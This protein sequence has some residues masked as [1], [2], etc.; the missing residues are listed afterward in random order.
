MADL[1][2]TYNTPKFPGALSGRQK[3]YLGLKES[4]VDT[5]KKEVEDFL[6][7]QDS[8]T[9][10]YPARRKIKRNR[11][12]V[13]GSSHLAQVDLLSMVSLSP[14]NDGYKYIICFVDVLSKF[15]Y[16]E[17]LKSKK[18]QDIIS[19]FRKILNRAVKQNRLPYR[20]ATDMGGEFMSAKWNKL[21]REYA[22][23]H[24]TL[25][26]TETKATN[27]EI[28]QKTLKRL[29]YKFLTASGSR[30]Y[31]DKLQELMENYNRS[32]H[33]TIGTAP[34][35]VKK[36]GL[37]EQL[38]WRRQYE[39]P[40]PPKPDGAFKFKV[41]DYVRLSHVAKPFDREYNQKYTREVFQVSS[42]K[43]RALLN[44]YR[45]SDLNKTEI[46]GF[47]YQSELQKISFDESG[48]FK[49]E[50]ILRTKKVKGQKYYLVRWQDYGPSMDSWVSSDDMVD[51]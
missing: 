49:V 45:V 24:Y 30:R 36:G 19:A 4:G 23:E 3:F 1:E 50:K 48:T 40:K 32:Y 42:R 41:K 15:A 38:V 21:M 26:N 9:L 7:T 34:A 17:I 12:V 5:S 44:L 6:T 28:F 39:K 16:C 33:R 51:L 46:H 37:L 2:L 35:N 14:F 11:V 22:I 29:I 8:Y 13:G 27:V 43:K 25:G 47:F 20:V 10:H 31:V 18:A